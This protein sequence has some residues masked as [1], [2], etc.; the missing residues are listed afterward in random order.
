MGPG[1]GHKVWCGLE[2]GEEDIDW[3]IREISADKGLGVVAL[4][5]IPAGFRIMVE[6]GL[7]IADVMKGQPPAAVYDLCPKGGTLEE[8]WEL[9]VIG[10]GGRD[11]GVLCVRGSR[12]NHACDPNACHFFESGSGVKVFMAEREIQVGE[13]IVFSY[14]SID[15]ISKT[16]A[17]FC[18]PAFR[19]SMLKKKWGIT[20][21]PDCI[22]YDKKRRKLVQEARE[23]DG[24]IFERASAADSKGALQAARQLIKLEETL[25]LSIITRTRTYYDA[26]QVSTLS[27]S[28]FRGH[29]LAHQYCSQNLINFKGRGLVY[30]AVR[31]GGDHEN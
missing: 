31:A 15:D 3:E 1:Q 2:Y 20:C 5:T 6:K 14:F 23:L 11:S 29:H 13:E 10:C 19:R 7:T 4:K 22:C 12:F 18:D 17:A 25:R 24:L 21:P 28:I 26:F 27:L 30:C 9:N 16:E 8:K